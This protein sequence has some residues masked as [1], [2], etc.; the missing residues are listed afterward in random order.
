MRLSKAPHKDEIL[1]KSEYLSQS[2]K[3]NF[4]FYRALNKGE[5]QAN[6]LRLIEHIKSHPFF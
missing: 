2:K 5:C 1:W 4:L 3:L 6:L